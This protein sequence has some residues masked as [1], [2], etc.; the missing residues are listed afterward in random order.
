MFHICF[1]LLKIQ[2]LNCIFSRTK[3]PYIHAY[4]RFPT[5]TPM[6]VSLHTRTCAFPNCCLIINN[7]PQ[8]LTISTLTTRVLIVNRWRGTVIH[9]NGRFLSRTMTWGV[10]TINQIVYNLKM[11]PLHSTIEAT[12]LSSINL[13]L[14][15]VQD[16][17]NSLLTSVPYE[18]RI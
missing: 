10:Y 4:V 3:F 2:F 5:Y 11:A 16:L 17:F 12:D 8:W 6:C 14:L 18:S 13:V 7:L 9:A 1:V 15:K